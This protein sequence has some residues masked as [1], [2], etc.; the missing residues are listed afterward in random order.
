MSTPR[1]FRGGT[2]IPTALRPLR[3][4]PGFN[5]LWF[6]EGI[7]VM[8]N[9]TTSVLL[10]LLAVLAF[11]AGPG[12][13]GLLTAA[14]WLPWLLIGLPA[15][16]WVDRLDARRIM[17]AADLVSAVAFASVPVFWLLGRLTLPHLMAVALVGGAA[18]VFF[19]TAYAAFLPQV[20]PTSQ[21]EPA[22]GRL[23]GTES[24]MQ[25][26]GPGVGGLVA[27]WLSAALGLAVDAISFLVSA[28]CLWRIKPAYASTPFEPSEP[29]KRTGLGE[30]IRAGVSF[31]RSDRYLR[32]FVVVGSLSN[33]GLTGY[34]TLLVLFLVRDLGLDAGSVGLVLAA[35]SSGGL[36]GAA[37]A[38]RLSARL[39]SARAS[40]LLLVSGGP[41]ALLIPLAPDGWGAALAVAGL[42][43]VGVAVVAG[44]V[45]RGAWRM[46]Y[47]PRA[48][49]GRVVTSSSVINYG[50]MP[51]AALL[52]GWMGA[53]LGVRATIAVMAAVH[54][55]ACLSGLRSPFRGMRELPE[56]RGGVQIG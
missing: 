5:L 42:F 36:V 14:A 11:D 21:L 54:A 37:I 43:L 49:M 6:G 45:V 18:T 12:S 53:H 24:A 51:L 35:G 19:R 25:I 26:V 39:G 33:L 15:G 13:M 29:T 32:Y 56:P 55:A 23:V 47:V 10:P 8:G 30:Q 46:R 28:I 40:T 38:T 16:A 3:Q 50:T 9:A 44:N 41:P 4:N 1:R 2:S 7:S 20:V 22:N 34:A 17:I 48:L 31:V 27:Q 52:S